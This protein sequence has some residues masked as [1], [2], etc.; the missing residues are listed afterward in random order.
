MLV[1]YSYDGEERCVLDATLNWFT[2]GLLGALWRTTLEPLRNLFAFHEI[3]TSLQSFPQ[4]MHSCMDQNMTRLSLASTTGTTFLA[5]FVVALYSQT[6]WWFLVNQ[7]ATMAGAC[8][9]METLWQDITNNGNPAASQYICLDEHPETLTGGQRDE[10]G[11]M[12]YP[13]KAVYVQVITLSTLSE[14]AIPYL[15]CLY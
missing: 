3:Q 10:N 12:F 4:A 9:I 2:R 7:L 6:L 5:V 11:K 1:E 13:V 15:C 14:W 8:S